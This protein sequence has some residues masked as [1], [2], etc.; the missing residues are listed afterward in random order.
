ML[1]LLLK[2]NNIADTQLREIRRAGIVQLFCTLLHCKTS[3]SFEPWGH[4]YRLVDILNFDPAI[5][6]GIIKVMNTTALVPKP[7]A[8]CSQVAAILMRLLENN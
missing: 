7:T 3:A 2:S 6:A 5:D 8:A 4:G 1:A